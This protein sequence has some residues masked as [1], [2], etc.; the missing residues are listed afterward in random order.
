MPPWEVLALEADSLPP[1]LE[2]IVGDYG[3]RADSYLTRRDDPGRD[4]VHL[5]NGRVAAISRDGKPYALEPTA[6][7]N[8]YTALVN[9]AKHTIRAYHY[10]LAPRPAPPPNARN[11]ACPPRLSE[12]TPCSFSCA[13]G[14]TLDDP[15]L[16]VGTLS[17][18]RAAP[19]AA[20][21]SCVPVTPATPHR[22]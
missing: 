19:F 10:C 1:E 17:C 3:P 7:P 15:S 12:K 21:A 14:F 6:E 13:P 8:A 20:N 4:R 22:C 16:L 5:L 2:G 11:L 9:G 18:S